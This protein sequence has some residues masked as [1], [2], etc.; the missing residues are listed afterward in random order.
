MMEEELIENSLSDFA[1]A[2]KKKIDDFAFYYKGIAINYK[3]SNKNHVK[4]IFGDERGE[5]IVFH[6]FAFLISGSPKKKIKEPEKV[7]EKKA[8]EMNKIEEEKKPEDTESSN[9]SEE[10][11]ERNF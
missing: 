5:G 8:P 9:E 2:Q 6:V 3:D 10:N 7:E 4:E 11:K 1:K